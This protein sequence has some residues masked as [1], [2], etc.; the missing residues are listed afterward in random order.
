MLLTA[1]GWIY[2]LLSVSQMISEIV[3]AVRDNLNVRRAFDTG[4]GTS[5]QN[6]SFSATFIFGS[7]VASFLPLFF[8]TFFFFVFTSSELL[9]TLP[10][11]F[12][13]IAKYS[14]VLFIPAIVV[15]NEIASFT[16]VVIR[17]LVVL[18]FFNSL[19]DF[20]ALFR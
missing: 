12:I 8:Y 17:E 2:L 9:E 15:F 14:I 10:K 1:E 5:L 13:N 11:Q 20:D 16:G 4:I 6:R 3:P 18:N 7:G 19:H